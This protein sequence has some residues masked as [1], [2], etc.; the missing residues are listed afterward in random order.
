[1]NFMLKKGGEMILI[2]PTSNAIDHGFYS[3]SPTLY[4]DYFAENNHANFSCYL[5]EEDP[6]M[7]FLDFPP[8]KVNVYEYDYVGDQFCFSSPHAVETVFFATKNTGS[9]SQ[10]PQTPS[11]SLYSRKP[12]WDGDA[13]EQKESKPK[14]V[15]GIF[16]KTKTFIKWVFLK[17]KPFLPSYVIT[18]LYVKYFSWLRK[19]AESKNII[20]VGSV[21]SSANIK[22]QVCHTTVRLKARD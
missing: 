2:N 5:C 13:G 15:I 19:R 22:A 10:E 9:Y 18:L 7:L 6:E 4:F 20:Y 17:S 12:G 21:H 8:K 16:A 11:Q 1:L 14:Q 3:I